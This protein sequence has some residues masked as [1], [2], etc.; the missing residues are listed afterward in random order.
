VTASARFRR[1]LVKSTEEVHT[2]ERMPCE[3]G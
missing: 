2:T 3:T 1:E